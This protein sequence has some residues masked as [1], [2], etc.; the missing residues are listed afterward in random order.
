VSKDSDYVTPFSIS[1]DVRLLAN[2][3]PTHDTG[4]YKISLV[5]TS[6]DGSLRFHLGEE[7]KI[8]WQGPYQHSRKDWIGIY[9]VRFSFLAL[10]AR[11][12]F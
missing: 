3:V 8:R 10:D 1:T 5:P 2:D 4:K 6:P 9:R 11:T 12:H 7:I